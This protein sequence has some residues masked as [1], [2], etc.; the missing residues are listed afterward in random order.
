MKGG[1]SLMLLQRSFGRLF[2]VKKNK[3]HLNDTLL[4][5]LFVRI[6]RL[7]SILIINFSRALLR[8]EPFVFAINIC[9]TPPPLLLHYATARFHSV[10]PE[11]WSPVHHLFL[12]QTPQPINKL[13][14]SVCFGV[15]A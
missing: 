10:S 8:F 3:K 2:K 11:F 14:H 12:R 9:Y 13:E 15:L 5:V 7:N 1:C 6:F 4:V